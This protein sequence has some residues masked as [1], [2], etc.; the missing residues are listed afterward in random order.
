MGGMSPLGTSTWVGGLGGGTILFS[1]PNV[2]DG[3]PLK[4]VSWLL[5]GSGLLVVIG[6]TRRVIR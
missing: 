3:L 5:F 6:F 2:V 4:F 1:I